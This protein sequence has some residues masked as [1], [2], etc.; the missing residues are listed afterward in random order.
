[1]TERTKSAWEG[2]RRGWE[3][4]Q[5]PWTVAWCTYGFGEPLKEKAPDWGGRV[6][7]GRPCV[8][9]GIEMRL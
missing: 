8:S 7:D 3:E 9:K 6:A 5:L 2:G 1:M 4:S